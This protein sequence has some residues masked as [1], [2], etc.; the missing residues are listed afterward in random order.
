MNFDYAIYVLIA[1]TQH[2]KMGPQEDL[3]FVQVLFFHLL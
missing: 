3:R 1:P 2:I